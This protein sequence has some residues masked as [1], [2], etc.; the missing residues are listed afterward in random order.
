MW[1]DWDEARMYS[2]GEKDSEQMLRTFMEGRV[3]EAF[4]VMSPVEA[5]YANELTLHRDQWWSSPALKNYT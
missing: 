2:S 3:T 1:S 5:Q 4:K